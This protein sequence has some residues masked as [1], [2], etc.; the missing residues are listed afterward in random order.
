MRCACAVGSLA[1]SSQVQEPENSPEWSAPL[2]G[3]KV[4][5]MLF[6]HPCI[7]M[8]KLSGDDSHRHASHGKS[9]DMKIYRECDRGSLACL[10]ERPLL[11]RGSPEPY[12]SGGSARR[13]RC[14]LS[15][16]FDQLSEIR[17]ARAYSATDLAEAMPQKSSTWTYPNMAACLRILPILLVTY[18]HYAP[19]ML[20]GPR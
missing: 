7:G 20:A 13:D 3:G 11:V 2:A 15:R 6:R 5:V 8:T 1:W 10:I 4:S 18:D 9:Q 14:L 17:R 12:F 16:G 19:Q